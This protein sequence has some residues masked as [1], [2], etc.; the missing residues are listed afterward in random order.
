[1]RLENKVALITG[2]GGGIGFETAKRFVEE[3]ATVIISDLKEDVVNQAIDTLSKETNQKV[4]GYVLDVSK[5][6]SVEDTFSN[7][8]HDIGKLDILINCAGITGADKTTDQ[9]TEEEWDQVFAVDVKG[10]FF[11][12]KQLYHSYVKMVAVQSITSHLS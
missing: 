2:S 7:I 11:C 12:T 8:K 6:A 4:Y 1:M 10:V 9:L 5:E 3:G